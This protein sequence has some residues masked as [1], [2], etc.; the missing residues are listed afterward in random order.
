MFWR[1]KCHSCNWRVSCRRWRRCTREKCRGWRWRG[2]G[3]TRRCWWGPHPPGIHLWRG[4]WDWRYLFWSINS[5]LS[6]TLDSAQ[7][8]WNSWLGGLTT[9]SERLDFWDNIWSRWATKI[10]FLFI[11]VLSFKSKGKL[12]YHIT[13][14]EL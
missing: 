9:P 4:W 12:N 11:K 6:N 3:G 5:S 14:R 13:L 8:A 7:W 2:G 10:I 1:N